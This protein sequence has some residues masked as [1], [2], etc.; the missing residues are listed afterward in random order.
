MS[1]TAK[2]VGPE[3]S[4]G[5]FQHPQVFERCQRSEKALVLALQES[6]LQDVSTRKVRRITEKLCGVEISK[7]QACPWIGVSR[8]AQALDEELIGYRQRTLE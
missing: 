6:Y 8:M 4:G 3:R 5:S 1:G 2:P 7:D